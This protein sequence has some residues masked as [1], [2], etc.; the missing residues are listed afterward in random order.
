MHKPMSAKPAISQLAEQDSE[1][2]CDGPFHSR[3]NLAALGNEVVVRI[4]HQKRSEL[5]CPLYP[6][7]RTC[8]VQLGMVRFGPKSGHHHLLDYFVSK[9]QERLADRE[10]E[11]F[12]CFK[13]DRKLEFVG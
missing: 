10:T 5:S 11:R 2:L 13:I 12:G 9:Q 7:K 8:A 3:P 1:A 4:D 6:R